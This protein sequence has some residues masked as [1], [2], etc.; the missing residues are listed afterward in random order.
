MVQERQARVW[1][2]GYFGRLSKQAV[3]VGETP[4]R[5]RVRWLDEVKSRKIRPGDITLVPKHAVEFLAEEGN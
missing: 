4:K 2:N 1:F 3:V 5:Y